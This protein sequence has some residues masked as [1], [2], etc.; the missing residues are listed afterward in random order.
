MNCG[1][2]TPVIPL[3]M[4]YCHIQAMATEDQMLSYLGRTDAD[5]TS[6]TQRTL[7]GLKYMAKR[8][9]VATT[10]L[11]LAFTLGETYMTS[12]AVP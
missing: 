8:T 9:T 4:L 11:A 7:S 1:L 10:S 3:L 5:I 6:I 12:A 2:Q